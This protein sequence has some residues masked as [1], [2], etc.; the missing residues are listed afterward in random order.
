VW[1]Y[2]SPLLRPP[3]LAKRPVKHHAE[4]I[5][6]RFARLFFW[7]GKGEMRHVKPD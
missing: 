6:D 7:V 3:L 5:R 2:T 1:T 4:T